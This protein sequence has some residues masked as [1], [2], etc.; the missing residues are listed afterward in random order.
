MNI[1]EL[2]INDVKR[3]S[4][5]EINPATGEPVILTGDNA[6]GKSSVLDSIVFALSNTGL[7]DPIR[8]GRPSGTITVKL[9][10]DKVE[11]TVERKITKKGQYLTLLDEKGIKMP[12]AQ[13]FL[14]GLLGNYA[15]DPLEFTTLKP[16]DQVEALKAAA[17]L[18]FT[19]LDA[20]R[21]EHYTR[22]TD[23]GRDGKT[24]R[25]QFEAMTAPA[26]DVPTEEVSAAEKVVE[27]EKLTTAT[28]AANDTAKELEA[29]KAKQEATA[30]E[31]TRLQGLLKDAMEK[32]H[33]ADEAVIGARIVAIQ[34]AELA[35]S[36]ESLAAARKAI[37]DVDKINAA[38]RSAREYRKLDEELKALRLEHANLD[39]RIEEIDEKKAA[40]IKDAA[41]P[42][43]GLELTDEGVM[44][45]G[46][47]FSQMSTAEQ[48]RISTMVAMA[49]NPKL[50]IILIRE[51]ALMN[52]ANIA[53]LADL[54]RENGFQVWM[55][56]FQE[57]PGS[58]GLHI[59]DGSVSHV[60][61]QPVA[62]VA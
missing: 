13:T 9:G 34:S 14:N 62:A 36:Q 3:I 12:T 60:D 56:K 58:K 20:Q 17:G 38:V 25:A 46:T 16:K 2:H 33:A 52:R 51:G 47:F 6:Q 31:V 11:Y 49:Q 35:P 21:L 55:E 10:V 40:A 4:G 44:F 1:L 48:I 30:A 22:R 18:D 53:M 26:E 19:E 59:T 23:V 43:D 39:R 8:H 61:G 57:E 15:F 7:A 42:L 27:L 45:N 28:A 54:A 24:K 41:L 5:V 32:A 50:K 29:A 37:E